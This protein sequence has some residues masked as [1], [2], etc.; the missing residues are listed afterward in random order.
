[1][2][3]WPLGFVMLALGKGKWFLVTETAG[4]LGHLALNSAWLGHFWSDGRGNGL[5]HLVRRLNFGRVGRS[6]S[7]DGIPLD[8]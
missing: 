2:I 7:S 3:S 5:F 6:P 4:Q 1:V 8:R